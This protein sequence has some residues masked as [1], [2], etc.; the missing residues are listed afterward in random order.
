LAHVVHSCPSTPATFAS[1]RSEI[2]QAIAAAD[3]PLPAETV[4]E[5]FK[6]LEWQGVDEAQMRRALVFLK[7]ASRLVSYEDG[8]APGSS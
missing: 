2:F 3:R 7:K 1:T 4:D 8:A 5:S 6:K